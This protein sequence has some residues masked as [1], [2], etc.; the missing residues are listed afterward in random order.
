MASKFKMA[1]KTKKILFL[2][3]NC[4]FSTNFNLHICVELEYLESKAAQIS[5]N[6]DIRRIDKIEFGVAQE[7]S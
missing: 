2:L 7:R 5:K 4:Q 3:P 6:C 1:P